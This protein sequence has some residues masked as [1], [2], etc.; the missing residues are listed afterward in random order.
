MRFG[1]SRAIFRTLGTTLAMIAM[2]GNV[3]AEGILRITEVMSSGDIEDW[4]ELSNYGTSPVTLTGYKMDDNSFSPDVAV[5]LNGVTTIG[6]GESV[7]FIEGDAT[8]AST[9]K[10]NWNVPN[11][12]VGYYSGS[13]V[14]FSSG[15]DGATV[16]AADGLELPGPSTYSP[17]TVRVNFGAAT[18]GT[19]FFW[20]YDASGD[21]ANLQLAGNDQ[22]TVA[23]QTGYTTWDS[24]STTMKGTP[25]ATMIVAADDY[26]NWVG[27]TGTWEAAGGTDW[28]PP[29]QAGGAWNS[30]KT[31]IFGSTAGTVTLGGT[32]VADALQFDSP[33]YS[34]A[35]NGNTV[36]LTD[37]V[38]IAN[39]SATIAAALTGT[40]GSGLVKGG[41]GL[42][43]LDAANTYA[44]NTSISGGE[45]RL[46]TNGS[47]PTGSGI[48]VGSASTFNANGKNV[49]AGGLSG[50]GTVSMGAGSMTVNVASG[51][52]EF[53]GA[54]SGSSD[55]IVNSTGSGVQRFDTR[56]TTAGAEKAYTGATI[57]REGT[58]EIGFDGVPTATSEVNV[59]DGGVLA[60]TSAV[61]KGVYSIGGGLAPINLQGGNL[62]NGAGAT[63]GETTSIAN[64]VDVQQ[65]ST[66]TVIPGGD[67]SSGTIILGGGVSGSAG[68]T[69]GGTGAVRMAGG[70]YTG[71]VSVGSTATLSGNFEA[72][73]V[74][75]AGRVSPGNSPGVATTGQV[76]PTGGL[77]FDFE[78]TAAGAPDYGTPGASINDVLRVTDTV[79]PFTSNLGA[80]NS[81][82]VYLD[83]AS[84]GVNSDPVF[85]GGFFA[86]ISAGNLL[87]AV[88]NASLNVFVRGNSG[89]ST[90]F[91]GVNYYTLAD[92][93][94]LVAGNYVA[95][96]GTLGTSADFGSGAVNGS[97]STVS[98]VGVPEPSTYAFACLGGL[99]AAAYALRRRKLAN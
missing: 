89:G 68:L 39:A 99:F 56:T 85:Q 36:E 44:G 76:D 92:W 20:F 24:S 73:S 77:G 42:L 61:S 25:G 4:F 21:A 1:L 43:V 14:G 94:T 57:V 52:S 98:V 67:T 48:S 47:L 74:G 88:Q 64:T 45:L 38:V 11:V 5:L 33:G 29:G 78:Y 34:L 49:S 53:N 3:H 18:A 26:L 35:G 40:G 16:F 2:A 66:I 22:L 80:S 6:Q 30:S 51:T 31:A 96:L 46:G 81:L 62:R 87:T 72:G 7:V 17:P 95:S 58:L 63:V 19:S 60:L 69:I 37:G 13:K 32:I 82:N 70:G 50:L 12:Q 41:S 90:L 23:G 75:G 84:L 83:V 27:G 54:M 79:T 8:I 28:T 86:E 71:A 93:N 91:N 15:G 10:T 65:A 59:E 97:V 9:F 55:F